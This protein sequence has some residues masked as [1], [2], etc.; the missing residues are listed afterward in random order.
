MAPSSPPLD[1]RGFEI[2]IICALPLEANCVQAAF[3]KT[4]PK[5][6]KAAKDPNAYTTGVIGDHNVV[7]VHMPSIAKV[8]AASVAT[9]LRMSFTGIKLALVVGICGGIPYDAGSKKEILL[10]DVIISEGLD[11]YDLGRQY[12]GSF[13]TKHTVED[14]LSRPSQEIR[15]VLQQFKTNHYRQAMQKNITEHL[16]PLQQKL[17]EAKYPGSDQ[18]KLYEPSYIHKHHEAT[19]SCAQCAKG[20]KEICDNAVAT[21]CDKVGCAES[22]LVRSRLATPLGQKPLV[23]FGKMGSADTVMNS[24][25]DRDRIADSAQIIAFEMEG[26]DVWDQ[27]PCIVIKGV[28]DYADSHKMKRWQNYAAA[29][30]AACMKAF[31]M[32]WTSGD[33]GEL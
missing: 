16:T 21:H 22:R 12:P 30:A 26:A 2:A 25:E 27:L 19:S 29:T 24:A 11:Q 7:L 23:H 18:D 3:D 15:A 14:S 5:C 28:C 9:G 13:K 31:L 10:G 6:G 1:R 8:S 17:P 33:K 32:A 4:W 20:E